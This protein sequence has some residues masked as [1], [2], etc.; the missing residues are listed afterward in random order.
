M[1]DNQSSASVFPI[2]GGGLD[3]PGLTKREYYAGIAL[4]ALIAKFP[5]LDFKGENGQPISGP[6]LDQVKADLSESAFGYA[7]AMLLMAEK[8]HTP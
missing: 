7:D 5:L 8:K 3:S 4:S 2:F 6:D 1:K